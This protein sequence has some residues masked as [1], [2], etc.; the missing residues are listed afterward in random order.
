MEDIVGPDIVC[1]MTHYFCK[2]LGD[3][4]TVYWHQDASFWPLT[5]SKAVTAWIA[6]DN[7]ERENGAM[8]VVPGSHRLGRLPF[9]SV[10]DE[11]RGVLNQNVTQPERYGDLVPIELK[12]GQMSLHTDMLLHGSQPNPSSRR[13]I[14]LTTRYFPVDVRTKEGTPPEGI[15][16]RGCDR[17]GYWSHLPRPAKDDLPPD[18]VVAERAKVVAHKRRFLNPAS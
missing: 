16:C 2:V 13:R 18:N 15:I 8:Q 4:H 1:T 17:S 10:T 9:E 5:P 14:G 3:V 12:A 11:Q 6:V 7:V